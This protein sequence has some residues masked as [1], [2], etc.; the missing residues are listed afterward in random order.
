MP[1]QLAST[2]VACTF[3]VVCPLYHGIAMEAVG[4][5]SAIRFVY[6][7]MHVCTVKRV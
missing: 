5:M 6:Y 2:I 7:C 3:C 4:V 1:K